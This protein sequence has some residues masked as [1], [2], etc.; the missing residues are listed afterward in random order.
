M[1]NLSQLTRQ[2]YEKNETVTAL[3]RAGFAIAAWNDVTAEALQWIG[4]QRPPTQGFSLGVVLGP[5]LGEMSANL[6]RNIREGR[7]RFVM[8]VCTADGEQSVKPKTSLEFLL[9]EVAG[10]RKPGATGEQEAAGE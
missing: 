9:Q 3:Q 2:H 7:V 4:R 1:N 8:G 10:N 6:A 5:R